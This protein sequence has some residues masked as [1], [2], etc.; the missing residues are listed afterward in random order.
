MITLIEYEDSDLGT[1]MIKLTTVIDP[2]G[3][4]YEKIDNQELRITN[5]VVSI[6]QLNSENSEYELWQAND[7]NQKNPQT[8]DKTGRYSFLVPEGTYYLAVEASGYS[9]YQSEPFTVQEGAGVHQNIELKAKN[10]WLKIFD[11]KVMAIFLLFVLMIWN[12]WKDRRINIK[13]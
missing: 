7:Y 13:Y 11:W 9:S 4:V 6:Y 2:E 5:A 12:F 1:R 8:T 10:S 3:Y